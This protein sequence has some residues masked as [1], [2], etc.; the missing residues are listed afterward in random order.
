LCG[1][2]PLERL[3]QVGAISPILGQ[4]R[5][6]LNIAN[7]GGYIEKGVNDAQTLPD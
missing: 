4:Y 2:F 3:A 6:V 7:Q 5:L 1:N